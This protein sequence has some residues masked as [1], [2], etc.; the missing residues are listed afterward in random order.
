MSPLAWLRLVGEAIGLVER[1]IP[2]VEDLTGIDPCPDTLRS[3]DPIAV[4]GQ[5]A[6]AAA[7]ASQSATSAIMRDRLGPR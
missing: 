6:G 5:A 2:V 1:A 4:R 7:Q 3:E